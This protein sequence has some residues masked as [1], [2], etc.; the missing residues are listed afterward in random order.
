MCRMKPVLFLTCLA[1][2]L[3]ATAPADAQEAR[4]RGYVQ[5]SLVLTTQPE[6]ETDSHRTAPPLG[7]SGL[8]AT[9][10]AGY[11]IIPEL[12]VEV[13]VVFAGEISTA[14]VFRYTF[15]DSYTAAFRDVSVNGLFRWKPNGSS[16]W[17]LVVGG[18]LASAR[19]AD[20][21]GVHTSEY[22]WVTPTPIPDSSSTEMVPNLTFGAD[23]VVP[24]RS[25]VAFVGSLRARWRRGTETD[26]YYGVSTWAMDMGVGLRVR[27]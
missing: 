7:G 26:Q 18:G 17:E 19:Y 13:E 25:K 8:G 14:Q 22:A 20:R 11:F 4:P 12:A 27:F 2:V 21:D 9:A 23:A 5:G 1:F 15:V 3:T 6:G 16:P 10:A 24:T